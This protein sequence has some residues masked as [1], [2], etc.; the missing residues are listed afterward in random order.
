LSSGNGKI[1][2]C[3]LIDLSFS[4]HLPAVSLNNALDNGKP[5]AGSFKL[6]DGMVPLK[7]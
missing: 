1:K 6:I 5:D 2:C 4:P 3:T 7:R